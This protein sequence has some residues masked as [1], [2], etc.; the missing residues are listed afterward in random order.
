[1]EIKKDQLMMVW[2]LEVICC[3][4]DSRSVLICRNPQTVE[5]K[6]GECWGAGCCMRECWGEG[7]SL[8][9][10]HENEEKYK[11]IVPN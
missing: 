11:H 1:M 9:Q 2:L 8:K 10:E 3:A 5:G 6:T 4:I 7:N